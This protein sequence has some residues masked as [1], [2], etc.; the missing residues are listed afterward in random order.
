MC[1]NS[2]KC[3]ITPSSKNPKLR[4]HKTYG[5]AQ[6]CFSQLLPIAS[7][8]SLQ[9][10]R[11]QFIVFVQD[12]GSALERSSSND[13][14]ITSNLLATVKVGFLQV[15]EVTKNLTITSDIIAAIE[16]HPFQIGQAGENLKIS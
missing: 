11:V 4:L 2:L 1:L 5:K 3:T 16:I 14:N 8:R 12:P 10:I 13:L 7:L 9:L 6:N 15:D